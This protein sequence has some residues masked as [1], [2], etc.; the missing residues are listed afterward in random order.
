MLI[1]GINVYTDIQNVEQ[2]PRTYDCV[3]TGTMPDSFQV[4]PGQVV[5]TTGNV[6]VPNA[7]V[8]A[9]GTFWITPS[10]AWKVNYDF[11]PFPSLVVLAATVTYVTVSSCTTTTT[12]QDINVE[13]Q[14]TDPY[15]PLNINLTFDGNEPVVGL[16]V[17]ILAG[18][19]G[20]TSK[21]SETGG[22]QTRKFGPIRF[23]QT[24]SRK[25]TIHLPSPSKSKL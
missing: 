22:S 10:P 9:E 6:A 24:V 5:Q 16:A 13:C 12:T 1:T 4:P 14:V 17:D 25:H 8:G 19:Y 20:D 11:A 21:E 23:A 7:Y 15:I 3:A 18:P 2:L